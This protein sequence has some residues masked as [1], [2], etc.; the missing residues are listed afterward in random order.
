MK[1]LIIPLILLSFIC[2]TTSCKEDLDSKDELILIV[3]SERAIDTRTTYYTPYFVKYNPVDEWHY[4]FPIEG[5]E[6]EKG[7]EYTIRVLK[8]Y[9]GTTMGVE[10]YYEYT[11]LEIISKIKKNSEG[12][13]K[14]LS[15][16]S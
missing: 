12:L 2:G 6:H 10:P 9:K 13:P 15:P 11:L 3:A 1:K 7:Y 8:E 16:L 14:P 4:F 5:F